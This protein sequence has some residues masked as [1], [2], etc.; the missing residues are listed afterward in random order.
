MTQP[1]L[2]ILS[3]PPCSGKTTIGSHISKTFTLP[4]IKKD[5][6]KEVLFDSLG[7][8]DRAWSKQLS[9]AS[10]A[11]LFHLIEVE[12]RA[13]KSLVVEGNFD[14]GRDANKL[15]GLQE[16]YHFFS[17]EVLCHCDGE[18]LYER[19]RTRWESGKRH[20]GHVDPATY[21]EL[22]DTLI[23][24]Y[25]PPLGLSGQVIKV[26]TTD[27][28]NVDYSGLEAMVSGVLKQGANRSQVK[29]TL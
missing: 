23:K 25:I 6:I 26:D 12:L 28:Q 15:I 13:G 8:K 24:G 18:T 22:K 5:G 17:L 4:F 1:I 27:F 9:H 7:W 19:F 16:N 10:Y 21:E 3:G 11:L 20:P 14:P 29:K 2:I